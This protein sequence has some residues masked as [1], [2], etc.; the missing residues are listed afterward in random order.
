MNILLTGNNS[1]KDF[2]K[3]LN[4]IYL[5]ITTNY[6]HDVLVDDYVRND[7]IAKL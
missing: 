3:I 5:H 7:K 4:D 1:K 6:N 2:Y